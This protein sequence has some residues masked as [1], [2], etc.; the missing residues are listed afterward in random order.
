[1]AEAPFEAAVR[2]RHKGGTSVVDK[3][4]ATKDLQ[5]L[6]RE[7]ERVPQ[8]I[9]FRPSDSILYPDPDQW[10]P[11]IEGSAEPIVIRNAVDA[12]ATASGS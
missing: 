2:A 12:E 4:A 10:K 5:R 3:L 8:T 9:P 1:M 6:I 11:L 7:S